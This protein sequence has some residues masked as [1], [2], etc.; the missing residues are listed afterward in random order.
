M[1]NI[2][3]VGGRKLPVYEGEVPPDQEILKIN[4]GDLENVERYILAHHEDFDYDFTD[5]SVPEKIKQER[6]AKVVDA[7]CNALVLKFE[8]PLVDKY[9]QAI[10]IQLK[11]GM[12]RR[13]P[14]QPRI[15]GKVMKDARAHHL[16]TSKR[17]GI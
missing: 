10:L 3:D 8:N 7:I 5:D 12:Q 13:D 1:V 11:K 16:R 9:F 2:R 6:E 14:R 4:D 17:G 15:S